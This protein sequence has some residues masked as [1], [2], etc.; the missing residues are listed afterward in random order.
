MENRR[1]FI[2][3]TGLAL[4]SVGVV[5]KTGAIAL[6]NTDFSMLD[7]PDEQIDFLKNLTD[8]VNRYYQVVLEEKRKGVFK[9]NKRIAAMADEVEH[10][11]PKAAQYLDNPVFKKHFMDISFKLTDAVT[12]D[13]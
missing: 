8:W 1:S 4:G 2:K 10:W 12:P 11:M 5:G 9:D 13:Y 6:I 3:K 7:L